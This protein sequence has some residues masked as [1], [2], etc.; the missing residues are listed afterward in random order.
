MESELN[1]S[2]RASATK[3]LERELGSL[4]SFMTELDQQSQ[5]SRTQTNEVY[6]PTENVWRELE[7]VILETITTNNKIHPLKELYD[8]L[9]RWEVEI[10]E[11][12][13]RPKSKEE[14]LSSSPENFDFSTKG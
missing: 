7:E 12:K 6:P 8:S 13:E 4:E 3:R 10:N 2:A 5:I 1:D 9:M 11:E 14:T